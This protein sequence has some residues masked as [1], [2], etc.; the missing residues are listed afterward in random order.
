MQGDDNLWRSKIL[1]FSLLHSTTPPYSP[2]QAL[3]LNNPQHNSI[4]SPNYTMG[5]TYTK[6]L[7]EV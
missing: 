7:L 4:V 1:K 5:V 6:T 2:L 3:P